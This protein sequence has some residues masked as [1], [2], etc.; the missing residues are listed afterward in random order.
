MATDDFIEVARF[1]SEL[2][3]EAIGHALDQYEIPFFVKSE[4]T[5]FGQG[6]ASAS[7]KSASL[8][9]PADR[10]AEVSELL[11][12]VV[13]LPPDAAEEMGESS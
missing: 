1:G 9:V 2:E 6:M 3:A 13:K 7:I 11:G 10:A 8:W 5:I 4:D 12:C